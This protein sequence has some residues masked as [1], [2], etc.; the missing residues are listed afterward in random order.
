M[1]VA[2]ILACAAGALTC[3][4]RDEPN[5]DMKEEGTVQEEFLLGFSLELEENC[6]KTLTV[7]QSGHCRFVLETNVKLPDDPVI[8][9]YSTNI[10]PDEARALRDRLLALKDA[11]LPQSE[12]VSGNSVYH[13]FVE[14]NGERISGAFDPYMVP[15]RH[16][17]VARQVLQLEEEALKNLVAGLKLSVSPSADSVD[18]ES[19]LQVTLHITGEGS[20]PIKF[21]NPVMPPESVLGW[22]A[23]GGVRSDIKPEDLCLHHRQSHIFTESEIDSATALRFRNEEIIDLAPGTSIPLVFET[24]LDWP[25]GLYELQVTCNMTGNVD[26]EGDLISGR[27]RSLPFTLT[28]TG[29]SKPED[30]TVKEED[31][32]DEPPEPE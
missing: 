12:Q 8:G 19:P 9:V 28:V 16:Q 23:I 30:T 22:I 13:V 17:V 10:S 26:V 15:E 32:G 21:Y 6:S 25:P 18:R 3:G 14:Q 2:L 11:D 20:E 1:I 24:V 29:Q 4:C 31:S 27:I 5:P 7:D